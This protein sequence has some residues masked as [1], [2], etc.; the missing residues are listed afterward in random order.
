MPVATNGKKGRQQGTTQQKGRVTSPD[1]TT[2]S[3]A[4]ITH[5]TVNTKPIV[6]KVIS[7]YVDSATP[8]TIGMMVIFFENEKTFLK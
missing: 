4:R 7:P 8:S 5:R 2:F 3:A 6:V 1:T